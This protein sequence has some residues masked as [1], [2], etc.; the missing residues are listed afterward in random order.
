MSIKHLKDLCLHCLLCV[1][2]GL[3]SLAIFYLM[4]IFDFKGIEKTLNRC[5]ENYFFS[6]II[7]DEDSYNFDSMDGC[8][9]TGKGLATCVYSVKDSNIN[10][11]YNIRTMYPCENMR[12]KVFIDVRFPASY[13]PEA[14][15]FGCHCPGSSREPHLHRLLVRTRHGGPGQLRC[16]TIAVCRGERID[17]NRFARYRAS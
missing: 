12:L 17:P 9:K 15:S 5:G 6:T 1:I 13:P 14:C 16:S 7:L 4:E 2:V 3:Q 11:Y 10:S 8:S